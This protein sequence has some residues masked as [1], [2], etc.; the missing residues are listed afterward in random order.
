MLPSISDTSRLYVAPA[1]RRQRS[2][3]SV[4]WG[5]SL[6]KLSFDSDPAEGACCSSVI[7]RSECCEANGCPKKLVTRISRPTSQFDIG[8]RDDVRSTAECRGGNS[9]RIARETKFLWMIDPQMR[10]LAQSFDEEAA[11]V[12]RLHFEVGDRLDEV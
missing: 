7:D 3:W 9:G 6:S 1:R 11:V 12:T 10:R 5:S 2:A 4:S 8:F